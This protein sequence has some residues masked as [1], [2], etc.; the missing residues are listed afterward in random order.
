MTYLQYLTQLSGKEYSNQNPGTAR[1]KQVLELLGNPQNK[2]PVIHIAGIR[3]IL[4]RSY[5]GD[6]LRDYFG[7]RQSDPP[8]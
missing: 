3:V 1:V 2:F 8:I 5:S 7:Y 4:S 6:S